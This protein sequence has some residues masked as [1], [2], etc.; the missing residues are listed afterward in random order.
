MCN[1]IVKYLSLVGFDIFENIG[2]MRSY[3]KAQ[4][5]EDQQGMMFTREKSKDIG[6]VETLR[7]FSPFPSRFT[8]YG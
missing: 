8:P 2:F 7:Y 4:E 5:E 1:I 3:A 6:A